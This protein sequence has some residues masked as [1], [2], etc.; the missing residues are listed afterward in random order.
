MINRPAKM[1]LFCWSQ[2]HKITLMSLCDTLDTVTTCFLLRA[3]ITQHIKMPKSTVHFLVQH[4]Y[5]SFYGTY[6]LFSKK[7]TIK[8]I[9]SYDN[10]I[11]GAEGI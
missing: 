10:N 8:C 4:E 1:S 2:M 7:S 6:I 3:F 9:R 11:C 5:K